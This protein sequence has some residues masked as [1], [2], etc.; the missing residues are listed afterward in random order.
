L[1]SETSPIASICFKSTDP[2]LLD[3]INMDN[4]RSGRGAIS[5]SLVTTV[6]VPSP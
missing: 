2:P 4:P 3:D 6:A 1:L 5:H